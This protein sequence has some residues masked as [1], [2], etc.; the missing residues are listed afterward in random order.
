MTADP[1]VPPRDAPLPIK[2]IPQRHPW[3]YVSAAVLLV[4][5]AMLVNSF[6]HQP[7]VGLA[8]G[9]AVPVLPADPQGR[10]ADGL[11]DRSPRW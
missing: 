10:L 3:R 2:A 7:G 1:T 8:D 9:L 5:A 4:L 11:G 6:A